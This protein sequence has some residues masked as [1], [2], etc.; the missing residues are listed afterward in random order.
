MRLKLVSIVMMLIFMVASV[1]P[2]KAKAQGLVEYALILVVVGVGCTS[3][4]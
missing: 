4:E 2:I 3:S 1:P